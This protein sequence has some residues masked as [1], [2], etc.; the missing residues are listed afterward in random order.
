MIYIVYYIFKK[1]TNDLP[2]LDAKNISQIKISLK[3]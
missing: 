3:V 1:Y 2:K